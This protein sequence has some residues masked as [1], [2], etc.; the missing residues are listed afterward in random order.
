LTQ[1][2]R[3]G[4][5]VVNVSAVVA[6]AVNVVGRREIVGFDIVTTRTPPPGRRSCGRWW[7]VACGRG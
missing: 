6:A 7:L 5:R 4:G 2:V 3:E 1:K